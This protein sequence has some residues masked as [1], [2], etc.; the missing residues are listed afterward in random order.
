V[1]E[2][3]ADE[4]REQEIEWFVQYKYNIKSDLDLTSTRT[5]QESTQ[6][7]W[8]QRNIMS[9]INHAVP[10]VHADADVI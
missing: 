5:G 6:D 1:N 2:V 10:V 7:Y 3:V 9:K 8:L 4:M